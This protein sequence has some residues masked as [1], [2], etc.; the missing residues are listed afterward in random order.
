MAFFT[1]FEDQWELIKNGETI[2]ESIEGNFY[3]NEISLLD[4]LYYRS[5]PNSFYLVMFVPENE[6]HRADSALNSTVL[7]SSLVF[8][9]LTL[10]LGWSFGMTRARNMHY[11]KTT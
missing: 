2:I 11:K 5:S 10:L 8:V 6:I 4:P 1:D 9:P 7:L 3:I